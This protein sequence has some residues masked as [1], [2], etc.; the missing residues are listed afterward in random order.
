MKLGRQELTDSDR[1][2]IDMSYELAQQ[3]ESDCKVRR[4]DA[5]LGLWN[6]QGSTQG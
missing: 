1:R 2:F 4:C 3:S 6:E 5:E